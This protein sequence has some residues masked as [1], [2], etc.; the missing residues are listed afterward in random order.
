[1]DFFSC[2]QRPLSELLYNFFSIR[3]KIIGIHPISIASY[4]SS[5][6]E[7]QLWNLV[8]VWIVSILWRLPELAVIIASLKTTNLCL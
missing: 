3:E 2:Q 8:C 5:N 1:M 7:K 4:V 6:G